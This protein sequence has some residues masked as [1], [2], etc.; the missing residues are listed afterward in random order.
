[1]ETLGCPDFA[2]SGAEL[3]KLA[4]R[5]G[6]KVLGDG[7]A[8]FRGRAEPGVSSRPGRAVEPERGLDLALSSPQRGAAVVAEKY[9]IN[10]RASGRRVTLEYDENLRGRSGRVF[11][12]DPT[13]INFGPEACQSEEELARTIAHELRHSRGCFGSGPNTELAA[14]ATENA[15]GKYVR[16]AL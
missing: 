8:A 2:W 7:D 4:K 6:S 16:G 14:E 15:L 11:E 3:R 12:D 1:M 10:L 13:V 5:F 9:G